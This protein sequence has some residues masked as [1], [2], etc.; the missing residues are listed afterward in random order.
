[1]D[2]TVIHPTAHV[3]PNAKLDNG[4]RVGPFCIVGPNVTLGQGTVLHSHVVV[5]GH[6]TLGTG[7]EV[8]PFASVGHAPQDLKYKGEPTKLLIGNNNR[9]RES[10]TLQPGTVQDRG[11]TIVG[12]GNLF[13][14]Y[15][16]VAH[17]CVV[18]DGNVFANGMQLAGHVFVGNQTIVGALC[19][20]HQFCRI[21]DLAM[22]GAGSMVT[23]DVPPF[24]NCQGDRAVLRGLNVIG[25]K[26][27]GYVASDLAKIKIAYKNIF[28]K[29][30][31]TVAEAL[32]EC[33]TEGLLES[34]AVRTFCH[35]V[36]AST[37]GVVRPEV[38]STESHDG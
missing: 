16:H 22:V 18:G 34:E 19:G 10:A 38:G 30:H 12:S 11:E 25:L 2:S 37:R 23:H 14:A 8:F 36:R 3:H 33:E 4:V 35:F 24:T 7:N 21:G 29:G 13:M 17:D 32:E 26:R 28:L 27:K 5:E 9:I 1:M 31:N 6:T 15:T 20:I